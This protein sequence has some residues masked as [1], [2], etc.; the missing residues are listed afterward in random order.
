MK[1]LLMTQNDIASHDD[2][3]GSIKQKERRNEGKEGSTKVA[4]GEWPNNGQVAAIKQQT[5]EG[6]KMT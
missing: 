1:N 2:D 6:G 3:N 5:T 4:A